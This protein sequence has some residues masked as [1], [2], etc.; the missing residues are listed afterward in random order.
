MILKNLLSK[1]SDMYCVSGDEVTSLEK[2]VDFLE[3]RYNN[4]CILSGGNIIMNFGKREQGK[5]HVLIDAHIDEIGFVCSYIDDEGFIVPA[6][7]GG[8]DYRLFPAQQVV[9]HGK[10]DIPG[11]ISSVPPHLSDGNGV[12]SSASDLLIDTGYTKEQLEELVRPGD[13]VSFATKTAELLNDRMCGKSFD[14]RAGVAAVIKMLDVL[15][16]YDDIS[17]SYTVLFSATEEVGQRGA[18]TACFDIAPD[19]AIAVDMGFAV[20]TGEDA[21]KCGEMGK[22]PMIGVSPSL[23]REITDMLICT[24]NKRGI[25]YQKEIMSGL[26]GTN[27]DRFGISGCG[28]KT[29]TCS[30]PLRYMHT[31]AEVV[32]VNDIEATA[33][34]LAEF[35]REVK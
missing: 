19:I 15:K 7:V 23:S 11:I 32:D 35:I 34:L 29:C 14:D 13:T 8:M 10:K 2:F 26:T 6:N 21:K 17:C 28:V 5:K 3:G 18:K 9:V 12:I 27:A 16:E 30:I 22:G 4:E 25:S 31:A 20:S 1:L 33:E 24:A